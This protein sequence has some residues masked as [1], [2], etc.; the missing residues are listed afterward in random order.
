MNPV[1]ESIR[2]S[3]L[4][5]QLGW[6]LRNYFKK[7]IFIYWVRSCRML[8][9]Q[10]QRLGKTLWR[11]FSHLGPGRLYLMTIIDG[12]RNKSKD[13]WSDRCGFNALQLILTQEECIANC[14]CIQPNTTQ[15]PYS[16]LIQLATKLD[17]RVYFLKK[18]LSHI[19]MGLN[20]IVDLMCHN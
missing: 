20:T 5:T 15:T 14:W 2:P 1:E 6:S 4:I 16:V 11:N 13:A 3:R 17:L 8:S 12:F 10:E 18:V 19:L 7:Y 9:C